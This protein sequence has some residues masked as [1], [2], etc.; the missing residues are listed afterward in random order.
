MKTTKLTNEE[1]LYLCNKDEDHFFDKKAF[2]IKGANVQ[3][4]AVAFANSD[5]G[6][7]VFGIADDAD[8]P[9]PEKRWQG[10]ETTE[11]YNSVI[12]AL[13]ELIPSIDFRFDF[14]SI[15]NN[16]RN[17]VLRVKI[18][19]GLAV[20]ETPTK[21]VYVRKGAQS[22]PL[23]API[24]ILELTHA[25]GIRSEE[26]SYVNDASIDDLEQSEHLKEFLG[27]LPISDPD[28]LNF[29]IKEQLIERDTWMP[30][31]A[32][33]L[34]FSDNPSAILPKQCAIKIVRYDTSKE[35]LDRDALTEDRYSIEGHLNQ[36]IV[37]SFNQ[38]KAVLDKTLVWS[39]KG[40]H[41]A[42]YPDEAIWEVLV[43]T[44]IHRD[45]SISD[46]VL[47]SVFNNRIEFKSPGRFAGIITPD[48]ILAERFSRNSK[49][50]RL[51]AKHKDSPNKELGEGMNTTF[52]RMKGMGLKQ[53]EVVEEGNYVKIIM[54]HAS[55]RDADDIIFSFVK[56]HDEINNRQA[57]D[58]T[59]I[60]SPDKITYHFS[61]LR[62]AGLI[63]RKDTIKNSWV[64]V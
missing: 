45:Y 1:A 2:G 62:E 51:L 23:T 34:L 64:A 39:L 41:K 25:K 20:H 33:L 12:Q 49:I 27:N 5:G 4:I 21:K 58:L 11:D 30:K 15:E 19:K 50:V 8:E 14:L 7:I 16:L 31:V 10:R 9:Q 42:S 38:I 54:R 29:L 56:K 52:Q 13:S 47:I 53:P 24:K 35:D 60:E 17:Y 6:E 63:T 46:N 3:K 22:L 18:N 55:I 57:R 40:L 32:S 48:N 37:D 44:V 28:P 26:D 36:Q 61:K 59:G 43:N